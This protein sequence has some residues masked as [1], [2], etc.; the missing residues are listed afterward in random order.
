MND[1]GI[2]LVWCIPSCC[3]V[4]YGINLCFCLIIHQ[5]VNAAVKGCS[6]LALQ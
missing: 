6:F 5:A 1:L 2:G 4:K 3:N